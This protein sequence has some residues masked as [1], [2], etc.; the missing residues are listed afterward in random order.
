MLDEEI[1]NSVQNLSLYARTETFMQPNSSIYYM[2]HIEE[3]KVK[4][5][6]LAKMNHRN[7]LSEYEVIKKIGRR[8]F[9]DLL[10]CNSIK[11]VSN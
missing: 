6:S 8:G 9:F 1:N 7:Y 10:R 5:N 3:I 2:A 11:I 4:W